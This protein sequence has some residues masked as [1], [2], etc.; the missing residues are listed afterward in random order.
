[1]APSD[2]HTFHD[3]SA[4]SRSR[5]HGHGR[6]GSPL[7]RATRLLCTGRVRIRRPIPCLTS[8][9]FWGVFLKRHQFATHGPTANEIGHAHLRRQPSTVT[10]SLTLY[11]MSSASSCH[12]IHTNIHFCLALTGSPSF[13][14]KRY[15]L[16]CCQVVPSTNARS[17][18]KVARILRFILVTIFIKIS[19]LLRL[20]LFVSIL[21]LSVRPSRR[22]PMG[23]SRL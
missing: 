2:F 23:G 4:Y 17:L 15:Q 16:G 20:A 3:G 12:C 22:L 21:P 14:E 10:H 13:E 9:C 5:N 11:L 19:Y 18:S 7:A 1:M 8:V 6:G